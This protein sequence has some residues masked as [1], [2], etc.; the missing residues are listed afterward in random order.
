MSLRPSKK[1][2]AVLLA[3]NLSLALLAAWLVWGLMEERDV[4][5]GPPPIKMERKATGE[6]TFPT[7]SPTPVLDEILTQGGAFAAKF[8]VEPPP[9][10]LRPSRSVRPEA[11]PVALKT[12]A[13]NWE[14]VRLA[15]VVSVRGK[16]SYAIL[17]TRGM[18]KQIIL[19]EGENLA[20]GV[21]LLKIEE[22]RAVFEADGERRVLEISP[23]KTGKP[24]PAM[25][26]INRQ[27]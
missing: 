22:V 4:S 7:P 23:E 25:A 5:K 12:K 3:V 2:G 27:R 15:G 8:D 17:E 26:R 16:P 19:T 14:S 21:T 6:T 11:S 10:A 18:G 20:E 1:T 9:R 13:F 24:S